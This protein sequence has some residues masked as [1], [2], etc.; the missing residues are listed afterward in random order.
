MHFYIDKMIPSG[1]IEAN[2]PNKIFHERHEIDL[3][4]DGFP[5][6]GEDH[7]KRIS[8]KSFGDLG[9]VNVENARLPDEQADMRSQQED[10]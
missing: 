3:I 9:K 1:N 7:Q 5:D 2:K 8:F 4:F 6:P 10:F